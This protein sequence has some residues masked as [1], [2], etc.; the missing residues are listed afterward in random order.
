[1]GILN[2]N[3]ALYMATGIDNSGLYDG[4]RQSEA[5]IEEFR[6]YAEKAGLAI[7]GYFGIQGLSGFIKQ[8]VD[9]RSEFQN[10]E[11]MFKVFLGNAEK[12]KSFMKEMEAYAFNNVFEFKD[13]TQQA[14]QLLAYGTEVENVTSVID[15]LSNVA[16]G[17]NQ[18]L[19]RFVELYNKAKSRGKLDA[20][21]VQQ[22]SA[23]GDIVSYLAEML[24]KSR[25][26][27]QALISIGKIGFKEMDQLLTNL[28][29]SGGKFNGMMEEKMKTLGDSVGLLQ[30]S[31]TSMFNQL[32]EKSE[33]YLRG[34]ILFANELVENY[35]TVGEVILTLIATYGTYKAALVVLGLL[36]KANIMVMRQA[37]LEK[38]LA[39]A[40][41]VRLTS[42]EAVQIATKKVLTAQTLIY[43]KALRAQAAAMFTNPAVLLTAA[44]VS[45]GYATYK[46]ATAASNAEI[47]QNALNN[48]LEKG[49]EKKENLKT[50]TSQLLSVINS[51]VEVIQEQL[52]AYK[53]LKDLYPKA[54]ENI[55]MMAFKTKNAT[56]QQVLLN[57]AIY[58]QSKAYKESQISEAESLLAKLNNK[59]T[60]TKEWSFAA[61]EARRIL[62]IDS[63]FDHLT[64]TSK[65][66]P[67][68]LETYVNDL[69]A[70]NTEV[71]KELSKPIEFKTMVVQTAEAKKKVSDL[72]KELESLKK[73]IKPSSVAENEQFDFA[74]GIEDKAK[75]LKEAESKLNLLLYGKS[76]SDLKSGESAADKARKQTEDLRKAQERQAQYLIRSAEDLEIQLIDAEI[77]SMDEGSKKVLAQMELNY[78]KEKL[79][80]QRQHEDALKTK[81]EN[82]RAVFDAT[83]ENKSKIFDESSIKLSIE[84]A[85]KF[86][87]LQLANT[88][89]YEQAKHEL[90]LQYMR[91]YIK[92]YGTFQQRK[93]AIAQEYDDKIAAAGNAN[94]KKLLE[95]Q[96]KSSISSIDVEAIY[97]NVDWQAVFGNMSGMLESQ[98]K[99]TLE[100][101]KRYVQTDEFSLSPEADK[102]VI[103]EAIDKIKEVMSGGEGTLNF[104]DLKSQMDNLGKAVNAFQLATVDEQ[105]AIATLAK[106]HKN[107]EEALKTGD[108]SIIAS[109]KLALDTAKV[110]ADTASAAYQEAEDN[111]NKLGQGFKES[112]GDTIDGLNLVGDGLHGFASNSLP[113]V[114]SALQKTVAGLS[115]LNIG[116]EVGDAVSKLSSTIS[117]A[118]F[119]GQ[120]ISAILS[121]LDV[122]KDGIG[123]LVSNLID[124]VLNAVDGILKNLLRGE[125]VVQIFNSLKTGIGNILNTISFGGFNSL[126]TSI[127]GSNAKETAETISRLTISNE[128]LKVSVDAL[129]DE[130]AGANG[131]KS[132][133]AYTEAVNAQK[134]YNDNLRQILDANMGYH[135]AHKSNSY[136]WN[137]NPN[138]L[139]EVNKQ[140]GT[141]LN[142]T[143]D[144]FSKL[145]ADQMNEIRKHL[146]DIWAEMISQGKYGDRFKD[147]W[148]NYADQAGK[149]ADLTDDLRENIA[150]ISF[151][152]LRDS[153]VDALM[154][155]DSDAKDFAGNFEEYLTKA[156]LNFAIGDM[157]DEDLK[158]W[159][160]SWTDSMNNQ[161]GKL[162]QEQIE[163]YKKQWDA[164][165]Q[166]G[167]KKRDEIADLTGYTGKGKGEQERIGASKG[168]ATA[169]QDSINE[170][171]GVMYAVRQMVGDIRAL[172]VDIKENGIKLNGIVIDIRAVMDEHKQILSDSLHF[173]QQIAENTYRTAAILDSIESNGLRVKL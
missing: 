68:L 86:Q 153:F 78:K 13:L 142:N 159:Y 119:I 112:A 44:V 92:E 163:Q 5:R 143:W 24:G 128:A 137:L 60:S 51:E 172:N 113:E 168:I 58:E 3:G 31:L 8:I 165:V 154:D 91:D 66:I 127:N 33:D 57:K 67:E 37:V 29:S 111:V 118:G 73:G 6:A 71:K 18:P 167:L 134:R 101:L 170:L 83:P 12:A 74:K 104:K 145:T 72:N 164:M 105:N 47:S 69:K 64:I 40:A 28:T 171:N 140:L 11:A 109:A 130:M 53:E 20:V 94:E 70:A 52:T 146:P 61:D 135:N 108:E 120:I 14:A 125:M 23:M 97:Q 107:Y 82:S 7:G 141:T 98:L 88:Q 26:E 87:D 15:K 32:G 49:T 65:E 131:I 117:N 22:W 138:S 123:T 62:G 48:A 147:D 156:L 55:D 103:Y 122:L 155:M 162:T 17:V 133:E 27:T 85:K 38:H 139:K 144:D 136:Y 173:Q 36:E 41:N 79:A 148:N 4:L 16:A 95:N 149:L 106:A 9:V 76:T 152:S 150:Q 151:Q 157:L 80:L 126:I 102:K 1:M 45:L 81:I 110:S 75:E 121:I 39:A 161:S 63:F 158:K 56:E 84:E 129:K 30:D 54:L 34:G 114:F 46:Y 10:T 166:D 100:S 59:K 42:S 25:D 96:K 2:R 132:I 90:E 89:S 19:E 77:K 50:K 35:E 169:S 43:T 115:K 93:L 124:T 160:E 99:E 116:G 21:D